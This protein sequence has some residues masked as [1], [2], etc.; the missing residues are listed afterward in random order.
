MLRSDFVHPLADMIRTCTFLSGCQLYVRN[1]IQTWTHSGRQGTSLLSLDQHS[2]GHRSGFDPS[3]DKHN[4]TVGYSLVGARGPQCR[5]SPITMNTQDVLC[6]T[7]W[8]T[9]HMHQGTI[10]MSKCNHFC[11]F[12][13]ICNQPVK[14]QCKQGFQLVFV[15]MS[16]KY[17]YVT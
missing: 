9:P 15:F 16:E 5:H 4:A 11:K 10:C 3:T 17:L 14:T 1:Y 6:G 7:P 2:E 13:M 8:G 12:K